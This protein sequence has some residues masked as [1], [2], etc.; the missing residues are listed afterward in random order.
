MAPVVS[1]GVKM[2]LTENVSDVTVPS[3]CTWPQL[4]VA[5]AGLLFALLTVLQDWLAFG[6]VGVMVFPP[7]TERLLPLVFERVTPGVVSVRTS[8]NW[9]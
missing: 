2:P 9:L 8:H 4:A 3:T 6:L 5:W 7:V 1:V